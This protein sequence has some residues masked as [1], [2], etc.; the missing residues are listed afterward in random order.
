MKNK[1][2]FTTLLFTSCI[3]MGDPPRKSAMLP[4]QPSLIEWPE[5]LRR[6]TQ[7]NDLRILNTGAVEVPLSGMLNLKDA[8]MQDEKDHRLFVDVL[9]IWFCHADRGCFLIDS[10]LDESFQR[11]GNLRGLVSGNYVSSTRQEKGQDIFSQLQQI[12]KPLAGVFFT[13]LH[14]DHTSGVPALPKGIDFYV[15]AG[16]KY[17]NYWL[18][19]Y[20]N[21][22]D[23]VDKLY[24]IDSAQGTISPILG[25][26]VDIFGDGSLFAIPTPGHSK[27]NLSYLMVTDHGAFLFTGDASHTCRGFTL[28]VEPG[29]ADDR[30]LAIESLEK[31][32]A[33][34]KSYPEVKVVCG[35]E[36]SALKPNWRSK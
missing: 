1:L 25:R 2:I 29:W 12:R 28:G 6:K 15:G 4:M 10:G 18:L 33:F 32:R 34:A 23:A 5:V 26:V 21:H 13:H 20:G 36:D 3:T 14:G 7:I 16:E 17:I 8:R 31:L 22:L 11:G 19:Y 35:H 30:K 9:A 27:A 24:E